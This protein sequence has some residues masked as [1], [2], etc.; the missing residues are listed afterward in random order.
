MNLPVEPI[1]HSNVTESLTKERAEEMVLCN[2]LPLAYSRTTLHVEGYTHP[3]SELFGAY[4]SR[5]LGP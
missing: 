2:S 5:G 3:R 1:G 4:V